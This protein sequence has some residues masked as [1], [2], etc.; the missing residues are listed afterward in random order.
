MTKMKM[1]ISRKIAFLPLV[2]AALIMTACSEQQDF[3]QADVINKAVENAEQ[4]IRFSSYLDQMGTT[5]AI[6]SAEA[7]GVIG[8]ID[9]KQS[10]AQHRG[11]GVFGYHSSSTFSNGAAVGVAPNFMYNQEVEGTDAVS[12]VWSYSPIK[13]WPNGIDA[14]NAAGSPS[15]TATEATVQYLN[16]YAYAPYVASAGSG[17]GII[18]MPSN[19]T[20]NL[21]FTY[22]LPATPTAAN[23]VDF[24]WGVRGTT[25]YLE[26]DGEN[27]TNGSTYNVNLTKQIVS[28]TVDF[29]FKHALA[30]I[31]AIKVVA[32]LDG[33]SAAPTLNGFGALDPTTLITLNSINIKD[34]GNTVIVSNKFDISTGQWSTTPADISTIAVDGTAVAAAITN[35]TTG[36][37]TVVWE[38]SSGTPAFT[39]DK[40]TTPAPPSGGVPYSGVV[41]TEVRNIYTSNYSPIMFIPGSDQKLEFTVSYTVRTFDSKLDA[42]TASGE[43][44]TWSKVTQT[45]TNTVTLPDMLPNHSYTIV[46]HI[47]LTSVKFSAEVSDWEGG[48]S[49]EIWLPSNVISESIA[50]VLS[51]ANIDISGYG[52]GT[53]TSSD[54]ITDVDINTV[55]KSGNTVTVTFDAANATTKNKVNVIK[56]TGS[57]GTLTMTV[58]HK[59]AELTIDTPPTWGTSPTSSSGGTITLGT[60]KLGGSNIAT[61]AATSITI[62]ATSAGGTTSGSLTGTISA[63]GVLTITA[64]ANTSTT[65]DVTW[66]VTKITI[67]DTSVDLST[68]NTF[69]VSKAS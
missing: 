21:I 29:S 28:E 57:T 4:P 35:S 5:R 10:L 31:G 2:T 48:D 14:A 46:M 15:N 18:G 44:G 42:A 49:K 62:T 50:G 37:N 39:S 33:N 59:A 63:A 58:V 12:P 30:K 64:P 6:S 27:N 26:T 34:K 20:T 25:T 43:E 8:G 19:N 3:T 68:G 32:D 56:I 9:S 52:I 41:P 36:V 69:T 7:G 24:L 23:S 67:D 55:G 60:L 54:I 16:F 13:Y 61:G 1:I 45:I 51:S 40:W 65:E 17:T 22:K 11:F 66:T 47:G 53:Y 38:P